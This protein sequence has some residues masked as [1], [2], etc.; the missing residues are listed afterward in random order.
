MKNYTLEAVINQL[1]AM[2]C[3]VYKVGIYDRN[4]IK[5]DNR[6]YLNYD[7]I[8]NLIPKLKFENSNGKDIFIGQPD[9]I[10]RA[11]ILVDDLSELKIQQMRQSGVSPACIVETSQGNFQV[12]VSLGNE[13]MPID[14]RKIVSVA[15]CNR[16]G[17]DPG[18]TSANHYGRL[19]GFTNRKLEHLTDKGYPFVLCREATGQH[20]EKSAEIRAWAINKAIKEKQIKEME[21]T[22]KRSPMIINNTKRHSKMS[23]DLAFTTYFDQ[24]LRHVNA[25]NKDEDLSRGDFAVVARM[26]KEGYTKSDIIASIIDNSP[27]IETRKRNHIEDYAKRTVA[28]AEKRIN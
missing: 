15:L 21:H 24:W 20:A 16:F 23:P 14:Q 18:S 7:N 22:I 11:L 3:H 9:N 19:A 13:P 4:H 17:G 27:N 26:L 8:L 12:W 10:D 1:C 28:A 25:L 6:L 5:M 2:N